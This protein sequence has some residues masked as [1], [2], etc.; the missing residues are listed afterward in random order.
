MR[1]DKT[2][3]DDARAGENDKVRG[4]KVRG[5]DKVTSFGENPL[6]VG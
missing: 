6:L 4:K 1:G 3:G 2:R 5:G